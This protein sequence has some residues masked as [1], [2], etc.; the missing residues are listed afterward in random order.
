[1]GLD[2]NAFVVF[3]WRQATAQGYANLA[4]G[5]SG[6]ARTADGSHKDARTNVVG[7]YYFVYTSG[8]T[9]AARG[10]SASDQSAIGF[11][12]CPVFVDAAVLRPGNFWR[13][14]SRE[15][16]HSGLFIWNI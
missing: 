10:V 3:C 8:E 7:K 1:M 5:F 15:S 11:H 12:D 4:R 6:D 13:G 2:P 14:R 16:C 9:G